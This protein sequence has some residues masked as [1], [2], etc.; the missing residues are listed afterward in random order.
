MYLIGFRLTGFC[1]TGSLAGLPLRMLI[2]PLLGSRGCGWQGARHDLV[3][4][5]RK[6]MKRRTFLVMQFH[7]KLTRV[8]I[9]VF[10]GFFR[11]LPRTLCLG[12]RYVR[13]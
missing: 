4:G 1:G 7:V 5:M 8:G 3:V 2:L 12:L 10:P 6:E 9:D 11:L 13:G